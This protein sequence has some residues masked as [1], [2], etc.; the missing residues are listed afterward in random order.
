MKLL[1]VSQKL[2]A[3]QTAF[4]LQL[5]KVREL[6]KDVLS[7]PVTLDEDQRLTLLLACEF[8][9][10]STVISPDAVD[11]TDGAIVFDADLVAQ[12]KRRFNIG[13]Q[14]PKEPCAVCGLDI[15]F[16]ASKNHNNFI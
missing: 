9:N 2:R 16:D 11:G 14:K 15:I 5:R 8:A 7:R 10:V 12:V 13:D 1:I 4:W 6:M 3:E